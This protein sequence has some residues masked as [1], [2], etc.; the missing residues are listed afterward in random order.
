MVQIMSIIV[1]NQSC[2]H[3][4]LPNVLQFTI[5]TCQDIRK[6]LAFQFKIWNFFQEGK[7]LWLKKISNFFFTKWGI[8][9]TKYGKTFQHCD[10]IRASYLFNFILNVHS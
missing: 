4:L 9:A 7:N 8:F 6:K 3:W 1:T 2:G 10:L 5:S